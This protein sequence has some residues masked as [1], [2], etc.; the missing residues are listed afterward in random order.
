MRKPLPVMPGPVPGLHAF[1]PL[2]SGQDV[3]GLDEPGH[4]GGLGVR[5]PAWRRRAGERPGEIGEDTALWTFV[6][7]TR[8]SRP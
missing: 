5:R 2:L 1:A 3:D 7:I 6:P 8:T 4:D